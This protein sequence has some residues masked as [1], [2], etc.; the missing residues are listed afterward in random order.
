M[1]RISDLSNIQI[2]FIVPLICHAYVLYF[3]LRGYKPSPLTRP[4]ISTVAA[5]EAE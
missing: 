2:A 5:S 4:L 3:G 1:G